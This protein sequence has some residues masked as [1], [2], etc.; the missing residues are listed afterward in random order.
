M[1]I[2]PAKCAVCD[3]PFHKLRGAQTTC[4]KAC[5]QSLHRMEKCNT[6]WLDTSDVPNASVA[7][8]LVPNSSEFT[9][10]WG[11]NKLSDIELYL[12]RLE[13]TGIRLSGGA[14]LYRNITQEPHVESKSSAS[15]PTLPSHGP[16]T[17]RTGKFYERSN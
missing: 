3:G 10:I 2:L 11:P 15:A 4:S 17:S 16:K 12:M 8:S 6:Q 7:L 1:T 5:K 9:R 13:P 14:M